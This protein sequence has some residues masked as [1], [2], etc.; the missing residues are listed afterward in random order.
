MAEGKLKW[1]EKIPYNIIFKVIEVRR[2]PTKGW[3]P[4]CP[5]YKVG[6]KIV[7]EGHKKGDRVY[8]EIK[9]VICPSTWLQWLSIIDTLGHEKEPSR[10]DYS[11]VKLNGSCT[12][13]CS[14]VQRGVWLEVRRVV[15][16]EGGGE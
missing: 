15:T 8:Y 1:G 3:I 7:F 12:G 16:E 2:H 9:G 4:V 14:D 6:D 11:W 5:V 13:V 10:K